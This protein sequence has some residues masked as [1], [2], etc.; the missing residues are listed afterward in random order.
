MAILAVLVA[1]HRVHAVA[2]GAVGGWAVRLGGGQAVS[3]LDGVGPLAAAG[4]DGGSGVQ[5][6]MQR[7]DG[8]VGLGLWRHSARVAKDAHHLQER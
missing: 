8:E 5:A 7:G 2:S 4:R 1:S 3:W 6:S